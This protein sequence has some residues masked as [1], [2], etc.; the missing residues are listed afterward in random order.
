MYTPDSLQELKLRIDIGEVISPYVNL[1]RQGSASKGLCPFHD[2]KSPS[3]VVQKGAKHYHCFGCGAHGDAIAF[4][5]LYCKMSFSEAVETLAERF[6]VRLEKTEKNDEPQIKKVQ[7]RKAMELTCHFYEFCLLHTDEGHKALHY[8]FERGIDLDFI[9]TFRLGYAP[10]L[11]F[12]LQKYLAHQGVTPDTMET[13]GLLKKYE[14]KSRDFFTQRIS[15]PILDGQGSVIGFSCRKFTD[16]VIGGKYVNSP[17]TPLFKKSHVLFGLSYARSR[18]CKEKK[19]LIVEGQIDA[20]RLTHLGLNFTVAGQGTAFGEDHVKE[21]INLGV[22]QVIV[23]FDGDEAGQEAAD[24]VGNLFQKAAI[25]TKV[26]L[27]PQGQDPDGFVMKQGIEAFTQILE[28]ALPY[29]DF[30]YSRAVKDKDLSSPAQ[31]NSIILRLAS[32]IKAWKSPVFV[33]E[34]LKKLAKL[35]LVP[36]SLVGATEH[37]K[38]HTERKI[39]PHMLPT[40]DFDRVIEADILRFMLLFLPEHKNLVKLAKSNLTLDDFR[41]PICRTLYEFFLQQLAEKERIELFDVGLHLTSDEE[42]TFI[43]ELLEK[44]ISPAKFEEGFKAAIEKLLLR[45]W[46]EYRESIKTKIQSGQCSEKEVLELARQFDEAKR[47][48][49]KLVLSTV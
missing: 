27:L 5:M 20:L 36:E 24:K 40:V 14:N 44:K 38:I 41:V 23:A 46:M 29:L 43:K 37:P 8:L 2:E 16:D 1:Q 42:R 48:S 45:T 34:N 3:F 25:D 19:A 18:I 9:S 13:A 35:A 22:E 15:F 26:A 31:K 17:E 12:A 6:G 47:N 11:P 28:E 32:R 10:K 49:P 21:L 30:A 39:L 7:L 33:H 4:L